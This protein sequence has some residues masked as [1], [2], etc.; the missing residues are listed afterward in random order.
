MTGRD[1]APR[2]RERHLRLAWYT[3]VALILSMIGHGLLGFDFARTLLYGVT[4]YVVL[5]ALNYRV[6]FV[7]QHSDS[8]RGKRS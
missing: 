2:D 6:I 7:K 8:Q 4:A 1:L 5:N 3:L